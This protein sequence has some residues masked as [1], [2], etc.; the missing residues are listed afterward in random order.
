[1]ALSFDWLGIAEAS[2]SDARGALTIVGLGQ[3]VIQ[4]NQFP[5]RENRVIIV[6]ILD[7]SG[8]ILL[9]DSQ[10]SFEM[11]ISAPSGKTLMANNQTISMAGI[12]N[13][14]AIPPEIEARG[15]QMSVALNL[16][17]TEYGIHPLKVAIE[18]V[19]TDNRVERV[20]NFYV[21][22]PSAN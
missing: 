5:H 6:S 15:F 3:N 13:P 18:L 16:E 17:F 10:L 20:R 22:S 12:Q 1:M 7:D 2:V 21:V 9:P 19:G 8:D 14:A 4:A 11:S